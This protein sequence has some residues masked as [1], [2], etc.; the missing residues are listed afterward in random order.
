MTRPRGEKLG[1]KVLKLGVFDEAKF[2]QNCWKW[3]FDTVWYSILR[4]MVFMTSYWFQTDEKCHKM[5]RFVLDSRAGNILNCENCVSKGDLRVSSSYLPNRNRFRT[6]QNSWKMSIWIFLK[7]FG[8]Q[9]K[10]QLELGNFDSDNFFQE[11]FSSLQ[12]RTV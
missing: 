12:G 3:K 7:N 4:R 2:D 6:D 8:Q 11:L 1:Y 10:C 9:I 5:N